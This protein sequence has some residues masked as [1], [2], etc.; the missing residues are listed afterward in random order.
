MAIAEC[1]ATP[2]KLITLIDIN[3]AHI[4]P[5][6]DLRSNINIIATS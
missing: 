3:L 6:P 1:A 4:A 5:M 2:Y